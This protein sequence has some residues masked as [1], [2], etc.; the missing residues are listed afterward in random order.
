MKELI[1]NIPEALLVIFF[2]FLLSLVLDKLLGKYSA[3]FDA[4]TSEI[5]RLLSN[6]QR[7][8]LLLVAL[9]MA[10][11][12]L[13][14]DVSA[15]VA[16]LGLTGF[17]LGFA[18]KDAVSNLIAGVMIVIYQ[19]CEIGQ[20]I[21]VSGTKGTIVDINLRY[22]TMDTELGTCLI[23]NAMILNNKLTLFK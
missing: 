8:V 14:F 23:P 15:L 22:L 2:V 6:S 17:A 7:T 3:H 13:G 20:L 9:I 21:E 18:L 1:Y 16:G 19:P 5:F 12:K 11:G 10:L 4:D